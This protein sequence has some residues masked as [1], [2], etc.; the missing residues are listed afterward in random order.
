MDMWVIE[1]FSNRNGKHRDSGL[2]VCLVCVRNKREAGL[3]LEQEGDRTG[4]AE[5]SV[6]SERL[7]VEQVL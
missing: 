7:G 3:E 2:G 6:V 5:W 4:M 1:S